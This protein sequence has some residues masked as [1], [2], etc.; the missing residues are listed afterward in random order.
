VPE[1]KIC[2]ITTLEEAG[3]LN[4]NQVDYAGFVIFEKSKRYIN[5][6]QS[7]EMFEKLNHDIKKVAVVVSPDR[8]LIREIE[9]SGFDIIQIHGDTLEEIRSLTRLQVWRAV[10]I[11]KVECLADLPK[12]QPETYDA[13]VIDAGDYGSGKTFGWK[14]NQNQ[15]QII[16]DFRERMKQAGKKFVLAGGLNPENV[17]EGIEIF[18]PDILDVSSGVEYSEEILAK[19]EQVPKTRKD[20][21]KIK[22]FVMAARNAG[23][24]RAC[25]I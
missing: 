12:E 1:I 4:E 3:Y 5:C 2:G 17:A 11:P 13:L 19:R 9:A 21:D 8:D 16:E 15:M 22:R 23:T 10:N 24:E 25:R 20:R 18:T 6:E 7:K 14:Q